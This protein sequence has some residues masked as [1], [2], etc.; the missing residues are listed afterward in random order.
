MVRAVLKSLIA[1]I[2]LALLASCAMETREIPTASLTVKVAD[3]SAGKGSVTGGGTYLVGSQATITATANE[4]YRFARWNDEN[5]DATRKVRI[6]Y[7]G[8]TY[9]AS[10]MIDAL[11][12]LFSEG[13]E[14]SSWSSDTTTY[15]GAWNTATYTH[16]RWDRTSSIK[17]D[18]AYSI[19]AHGISTTYNNNTNSELRRVLYLSNF[20][21]A[22][23]SFKEY[24]NTESYYDKLQV[25]VIYNGTTTTLYTKSS[26]SDWTSRTVDLSSYA[27][28]TITL[29]F[30]FSSDYSGVPSSPAGVW[31]D[32]ITVTAL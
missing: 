9:T 5:K 1:V 26:F 11:I 25:Q 12:E 28:K 21:S 16:T 31:L 8:A 10:F 20:S 32:D 30:K 4:G 22:T 7:A 19:G 3:D 13:F 15:A 2:V 24:I 27:G 14:S 23:L 29:V 18:G 6:P 17:Y